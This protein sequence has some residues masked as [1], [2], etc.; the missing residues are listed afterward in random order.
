MHRRDFLTSRSYLILLTVLILAAIVYLPALGGSFVADDADQIVL[1]HAGFAWH[2]IPAYFTHSVWEYL[3]SVRTN[4]YRPVFLVWLTIN[5]KLFG[6]EPV[7]WHAAAV[8]LHLAATALL[9]FVARRVTRDQLTAGIAALIFGVHPAHVETVAWLSGATDSLL[10]VSMFAAILCYLRARE[11][12]H[13]R[14]RWEVNAVALFAMALFTKETAVV[15]PILLAAADRLRDGR[16]R[17]WN[18]AEHIAPYLAVLLIYLGAR[19]HALGG[20]APV[21]R[22]WTPSMIANTLPG[23]L[24][25]YLR[26]MAIPLNDYSFIHPLEAVRQFSISQVLLPAALVGVAALGLLWVAR[27][28]PA[29]AFSVALLALPL[30]PVL[31]LRGFAFD[32]IAHDR[33]LYIPSAGL[34]ILFAMGLRSI[35]AFELKREDLLLGVVVVAVAGALSVV[36]VQTTAYWQDDLAL[37]TRAVAVAPDS[38]IAA[39]YLG[40]TLVRQQRCSEA[41]PLLNRSLA[42][43]MG[44]PDL[45]SKLAYCHE[46]LDDWEHAERYLNQEIALFP[47]LPDGYVAL[48][49]VDQHRGDLSAA[50]AHMR[51][52]MQLR[53]PGSARYF[54]YHTRLGH[55]LELQGNDADAL[56]EYQA[57]LIENPGSEQ[58]QDSINL[59]AR[60]HGQDFILGR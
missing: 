49:S 22:A 26:Q 12:P 55:I 10:A 47:R 39:E 44:N 56:R 18:I 4:Y 11:D 48:T 14:I 36:T 27:R 16:Q 2:A 54:E 23:V 21:A 24:L 38:T 58:A 45:Y 42:M 46:N 8:A 53:V 29:A 41:L 37:F 1:A 43:D 34:C 32:D 25:F 50:A 30:L 33:Y 35:D 31:S 9:Y 59:L 40:S 60:R 15:L 3:L 20:L 7:W 52:A 28:G 57:E 6:L 19:I 51:Q 5:Y 13:L 17:L